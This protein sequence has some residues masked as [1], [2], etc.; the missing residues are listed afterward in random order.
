MFKAFNYH[1]TISK[2][3][4]KRVPKSMLN[5][6][7]IAVAIRLRIWTNLGCQ[8]G[9]HNLQK[10]LNCCC[11]GSQGDPKR[12]PKRGPR[13]PKGP[14]PGAAALR[15]AGQTEQG[16]TSRRSDLASLRLS[17]T[18]G[19]RRLCR[20]AGKNDFWEPFGIDFLFFRNGK[21]A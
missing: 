15:A 16:V 9:A 3:S 2:I 20:N 13:G 18:L 10:P 4:P 8:N 19:A 1:A 17:S 21:K 11:F 7:N 6:C 12:G 14:G 5:P